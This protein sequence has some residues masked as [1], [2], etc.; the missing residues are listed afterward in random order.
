MKNLINNKIIWVV[1]VAGGLMLHA[2]SKKLDLAPESQLSDANFWKSTNDLVLACNY[3]YS[4]LPGIESNSSAI[5]SDDGYANAP[6]TISDGSRTVPSTSGDW[7]NRYA[8]I[9]ACNNILEKSVNVPGDAN[10]IRRYKGEAWFFRAMAYAELVKRFGDVPLILRTFDVND[11]LTQAYR[12]S[13]LQVIEIIYQDLDSAIAVLPK[14]S[15]LSAA[16]YGRITSNA[17]LALK[18]KVG[19][20][21]GTRNKYHGLGDASKHLQAA[22]KACDTLMTLGH[23]LYTYTA[24]P[25]SSYFY[26]FQY[27]GV[28]RAN[29]ENILVRLYGEN[30]TNNISNHNYT[31]AY[32][33]QGLVTPTRAVMDAYLYKDGLPVGVSPLQLPQDS[34][35]AEFIDRDPRVWMTVFKKTDWFV[36]SRY[37]PTF[38]F[39]PTGYKVRKYFVGDDWTPQRSYVHNI[40]I[41]YAEILLIYAEL[42]YEIDGTI[43]DAD[44]DKSINLLRAR[45]KMPNLTNV[46]VSA[47]GLNMKEEIRRERRVELAF[48]SD[49]RYWDLIRW[50]TAEIELPKAVKGTKLFPAEQNGATSMV[51]DPNGFV[52]VQDAS[53]RSF[54]PARDYW[55]PLPTRDLGLDLNLTQ[56]LNW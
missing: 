27:A 35:M 53:K 32:L 45:A 36:S 12:T 47:N 50:K 23:S 17:A 40:I 46:F 42:K 56:N 11:T 43:A 39:A 14:A 26:L 6:N 18:A 55:W 5:W 29:K 48:E 15:N 3:L 44:L 30:A 21:E 19:L 33:E 31:R 51:T 7:S 41:R 38:Q 2:C 25:D 10:I 24:K 28:G 49:F 20:F 1:L 9:R 16:E 54:Q 34:T 8:L 22:L 52:I 37:Q 4:Y 13:R